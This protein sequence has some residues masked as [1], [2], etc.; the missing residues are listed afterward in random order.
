MDSPRIVEPRPERNAVEVFLLFLAL[1]SALMP[2]FTS[3]PSSV[4]VLLGSVWATV[5]AGGLIIGASVTLAGLFWPG[6]LVIGLLVQQLGYAAFAPMSLARAAALFDIG[7]TAQAVTV[8]AFAVAAT[9][10]LIQLEHRLG[11]RWWLPCWL[12]RRRTKAQP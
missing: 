1:Q 12:R 11:R 7:Q 2:L 8:L 3:T 10:R 4:A 6:R 9:I 5:W